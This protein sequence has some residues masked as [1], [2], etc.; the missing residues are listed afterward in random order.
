MPDTTIK[1]QVGTKAELDSFRQYKNE[2]YDE[3]IKKLLF[4]AKKVRKE[5]RLSQQAIKDIEEARAQIKRGEY[6]TEAEV[7]KRFGIKCLK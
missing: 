3:V 7:M 5:P 4:V 6:Y 2:S 1:V